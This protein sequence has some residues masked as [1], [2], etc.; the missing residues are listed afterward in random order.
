MKDVKLQEPIKK[1]RW[2]TVENERTS[3]IDT[4][5]LD[6]KQKSISLWDTTPQAIP[7][8]SALET[9]LRPTS[10]EDLQQR[11]RIALQQA[12]E[13]VR[14]ELETPKNSNMILDYQSTPQNPYTTPKG[15]ATIA[16]VGAVSDI[17]PY[18]NTTTIGTTT[19][20]MTRMGSSGTSILYTDEM[21][22]AILPSKGYKILIPPE[23]YIPLRTPSRKQQILLATPSNND[24]YSTTT[25]GIAPGT[26]HIP[27][28]NEYIHGD[29]RK[30]QEEPKLPDEL[31]DIPIKKES[32]Y[33]DFAKLFEKVDE[34][35][36][37]PEEIVERKVM[38]LIFKIKNGIPSQRKS[39][40]KALTHSAR[41]FGAGPIFTIL[42][43]QMM[44]ID[45]E[46]YERH[47]I[48]KVIGRMLYT[49]DDLVRPY[50]HKILTVIQP[51]LLDKDYFARIEAREIISNLSKATGLAAM[52]GVMRPDIDSPDEYTRNCVSRSLAVVGCALGV[53]NLQRFL[54]AVARSQKSWEA[55]HTGMKVIQHI[56]IF[57]G[58]SV[59]AYLQ[60][61][62]DIIIPCLKDKNSKVRCIA[63]LALS[64]LAESSYPYGYT[65]F[66]PTFKPLWEGQIINKGNTLA[67]FFKAI[68]CQ[69]PQMPDD[70][71][72]DATKQALTFVVRQFSSP[73]EEMRRI[74]LKVVQQLVSVPSQPIVSVREGVV[75]PFFT[76][77]WTPRLSLNVINVKNVISTTVEIASKIGGC[78]IIEKLVPY[79]RHENESFRRMAVEGVQNI[80]IR[81]GVG[82]I[83]PRL[84]ERLVD[85]QLLAFQSESIEN[86][87]SLQKLQQSMLGLPSNITSSSTSALSNESKI[88]LKG[89]AVVLNTLDIRAT[90][91]LEQIVGQ[92][93]FRIKN[94]N[95][96]IRQQS[97][98]LLSHIAQV[99]K[100]CNKIEL[101]QTMGMIQFEN[102]GEEFPDTLAAIVGALKSII[103]S[104]GMKDMKPSVREQLPRLTPILK[105][106][107][108]KVQE[109]TINL[110][111][112]IADQAPEA[113]SM[114]EWMRVCFDLLGQLKAPR[115]SIR[116]AAI[117][118][119]GYIANAIGP[120]EVLVTLLNNLKVQDRT[121][122]ICT[123]IAIAVIAETCRPFMV[124][125][126]LM[127]EYRVPDNN[128]QNGVLKA[129]SFQF[130][131]VGEM[132]KDYVY[133]ITPQLIDALTDRDVVHRQIACSIVKHMALGAVG[134]N[135]EDA[136]LHLL[137][138]IWPNMFETA[139][140]VLVAVNESINSLRI[141]LGPGKLIQ[142]L[143]AGL[144]HPARRVRAI[145]WRYYNAMYV[146]S[147]DSIVPF[148][149]CI[150]DEG[151]I[152]YNRW[153]LE[154]L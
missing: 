75:E 146:G 76:N 17:T 81:L 55:R 26:Y 63:A 36:Q 116:R 72:I 40:L 39:A 149:P 89:F 151:N 11:S 99:M 8:T 32:D 93:K 118:T 127:N 100:R 31:A 97:V 27:Q 12:K 152:I 62:V 141:A 112:R 104:L 125:P 42:L 78:D 9:P 134:L 35:T 102:L 110:L 6:N 19:Y 129:L 56:A 98:E 143:L 71:A 91:Y 59:Q 67:A 44:S 61:L 80:V 128:V 94:R 52:I 123:S 107:M 58:C 48:V 54:Q 65:I 79:I 111:G 85:A 29:V 16:R 133:A 45:L 34:D 120:Q 136:M 20:D 33:K 135:T 88:V 57:Q 47:L 148:Y 122:R 108:E 82:D 14:T 138:H 96:L 74:V 38:I 137:N 18:G 43:P 140:H 153:E 124:I 154:M 87:A 15:N 147:Q 109:N 150:Q 21:L 60:P 23:T 144:F 132:G 77:F 66:A 86:S 117:N 10:I 1:S 51:M 22:D 68:G 83:H 30:E 114:K 90:D 13:S 113:A 142:Y 106:Q 49:L 69:V 101:L 73:D 53:H 7:N 46:D 145:Y 119:F 5:I 37:S 84:E 2:D 103:T 131:Y 70:V 3:S 115:K 50:A 139:F 92:I 28:H 25:P 121:N 64:S 24:M 126:A 4:K 130:E 41:D 95:E 105:N